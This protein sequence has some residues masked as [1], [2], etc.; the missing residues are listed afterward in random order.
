MRASGSYSNQRSAPVEALIPEVLAALADQGARAS[1]DRLAKKLT[2]AGQRF[3][4]ELVARSV[5]LV[6]ILAAMDL[7]RLTPCSRL[8]W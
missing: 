2:P 3:E 1:L 8:V 6:A 4:P 5:Y 7:K